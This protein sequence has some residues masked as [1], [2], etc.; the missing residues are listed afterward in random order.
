LI[1]YLE[2]KLTEMCT[3]LPDFSCPPR[4]NLILTLETD[5]ASQLDLLESGSQLEIRPEIV[6]PTLSLIGYP[7]DHQS[8]NALY[9]G[10][11][12]HVVQAAMINAQELVCCEHALLI[13]SLLDYQLTELD[14]LPYQLYPADYEQ[15]FS[16]FQQLD[17]LPDI[18]RSRQYDLSETADWRWAYALTEFLLSTPL[19]DARA[20]AMLQSLIESEN[21]IGW[22]NDLLNSNV[23]D[24]TVQQAW[25]NFI[26]G[27]S[28][29]GQVVE[30]QTRPAQDILMR[31]EN[32]SSPQTALYRYDWVGKDWQLLDQFDPPILFMESLPDDSAVIIQPQNLKAPMSTFL[33]QE[34]AIK[35]LNQ[36]LDQELAS[37]YYIGR[38]A[39][40]GHALVMIAFDQSGESYALLDLENC[41]D[42]GCNLNL[43][44]GLPQWSP[45]S[46]QMIL[47]EVAHEERVSRIVGLTRVDQAGQTHQLSERGFSPFWFS[48]EEYGYIEIGR[49]PGVY[50]AQ[51]TDDNPQRL[52]D[53]QTL[54]RA[55]PEDIRPEELLLRSVEPNP[56]D[57]N[58]LAITTVTT[59]VINNDVYLFLWNRLT[60]E[61][62][63][64]AY[65]DQ[66]TI[67]LTEW[68]PGGEWLLLPTFQSS[69][70]GQG[71][72]FPWSYYLF[73]TALNTPPIIVTSSEIRGFSGLDYSVDGE[74][75][76]T[77]KTDFLEL[78]NLPQDV[79]ENRPYRQFIPHQY[80]N[81]QEALF[82]W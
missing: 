23:Y 24:V 54:L 6:L 64:L 67:G 74:W 69:E 26:Y 59:E 47:E 1:H 53:D 57:R 19:S 22:L 21:Y 7:V 62:D 42:D 68:L 3:A 80:N 30:A 2:A 79:G 33:W 81:C 35:P 55:L 70:S 27:K 75:L 4:F 18:W 77:P 38:M 5:P 52:L 16:R 9:R 63:Y 46:A 10:Y 61:L 48:D 29:S 58:I 11:A 31:C 66:I 49:N 73:N 50:A 34:N 60:G 78:I 71:I 17:A 12:A 51:V 39:P 56:Y 14:L 28:L 37:Y 45:N 76:I 72:S 8:A 20:G 25:L 36:E 65:L 82:I 13:H 41:T 43:V 40:N 32:V 15:L 44:P